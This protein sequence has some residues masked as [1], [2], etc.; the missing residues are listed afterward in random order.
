M[1]TSEPLGRGDRPA[2]S[3][4]AAQADRRARFE[5]RERPA[6]RADIA[7][8][9]HEGAHVGGIAA[10]ADRHFADAEHVEHV[11]LARLRKPAAFPGERREL[12]RRRVR[13]LAA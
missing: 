4:R 13:E 7:H 3:E 2:R 9:M 5:P 12:Q 1:T 8:G 11:E 10:H 6:D